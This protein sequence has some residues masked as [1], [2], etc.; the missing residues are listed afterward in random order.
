[1]RA[2]VPALPGMS[3]LVTPG[4]RARSF[5]RGYCDHDD[6]Y[7]R[8]TWLSKIPGISGELYLKRRGSARSP[9]AKATTMLILVA[10]AG[11]AAITITVICKLVAAPAILSAIATLAA[12]ASVLI[13]GTIISF[14]RTPPPGSSR[15]LHS[16]TRPGAG[17]ARCGRRPQAGTHRPGRRRGSPYALSW[18]NESIAIPKSTSVTT[19]PGNGLV[20]LLRDWGR[21]GHSLQFRRAGD[22]R[23]CRKAGVHRPGP[24]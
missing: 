9:T 2:A 20:Y 6:C 16:V 4:T 11:L 19:R 13:N 21:S 18:A 8:P 24:G 5:S 14:R 12:F 10:G 17:P 23:I 3:S 7:R 1:M 15:R 22:V